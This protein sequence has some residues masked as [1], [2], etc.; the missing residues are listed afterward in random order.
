MLPWALRRAMRMVF[1]DW[2]YGR[3][4]QRHGIP[5]WYAYL[6]PSSPSTAGLSHFQRYP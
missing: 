1:W 3:R 5:S 2:A 6:H 4:M